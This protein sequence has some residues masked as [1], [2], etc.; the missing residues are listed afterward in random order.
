MSTADAVDRETAWLAAF[1]PADGLPALHKD[2][3]G[4]FDVLQ[5]YLPRTPAAR[6]CQLY[7]LRRRLAEDRTANVRSMARYAFELRITWPL[8]S[9][10]GAA[11][12]CQRDLDAAVDLVLKRVG[13]LLFDKTHGNRFLSVAENPGQISVEFGDP[14]QSIAAK[15]DLFAS[16]T[17]M[18][19]DI[20]TNG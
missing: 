18:A 2:Q 14:D 20:E 11:E 1:D 3:G 8:S 16:I 7:V 6:R 10:T 19:D 13:G 15:A 5:A 12:G 4:P 17:Y 9:L